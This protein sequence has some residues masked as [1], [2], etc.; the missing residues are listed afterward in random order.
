MLAPLDANKTL[1][2]PTQTGI[3]SHMSI[4]DF[5][6]WKAKFRPAGL[7]PVRDLFWSQAAG[8]LLIRSISTRPRGTCESP[9]DP[10]TL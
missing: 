2:L 8:A 4:L 7:C 6:H 3:I 10:H 9:K 5:I 1:E